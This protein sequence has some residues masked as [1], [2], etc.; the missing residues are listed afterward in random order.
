[1]KKLLQNLTIEECK[2]KLR[3][4]DIEN[5]LKKKSL[6]NITEY[7]YCTYIIKKNKALAT[8]QRDN[9]FKLDIFSN[10]SLKIKILNF[11]IKESQTLNLQEKD[12]IY[13]QSKKNLAILSSEINEI[14]N[15]ILTE[16]NIYGKS[17]IRDLLFYVDTLFYK[18]KSEATNYSEIASFLIDI[19]SKNIQNIHPNKDSFSDNITIS[20][21][22]INNLFS[23]ALKILK[24]L[25]ANKKIDSLEYYCSRNKKEFFIDSINEDFEKSIKQGYIHSNEQSLF[26]AINFNSYLKES[27]TIDEF[28]DK[29]IKDYSIFFT[30]KSHPIERYIFNTKNIIEFSQKLSKY[31]FKDEILI[32]ENLKKEYFIGI[33]DDEIFRFEISNK[34][35]IEDIFII[36]KIFKILNKINSEYLNSLLERDETK[37]QIIYNS[38]IKVFDKDNL[39]MLLNQ[40]INKDKAE[41]FVKTFSWDYKENEFFD[42]L[43]SPLIKFNESY[44]VATNIFS[45]SNLVRNVLFLKKI[46]P[47]D[48]FPQ[49]FISHEIYSALKKTF[50]FIKKEVKFDFK[51][52]NG[53]RIHG[54]FDVIALIEDTLFIF[55]IKNTLLGTSFHE[56]RSSMDKMNEGIQQIEKCKEALK[57]KDFITYLNNKLGW[58]IPNN[59]NIISSIVL[60][61]RIFNGYIKNNIRIFSSYE[62]IN[63]IQTGKV[64]PI[65]FPNQKIKKDISL[66]ENEEISKNDLTNYIEN[67]FFHKERFNNLEAYTEY[68]II[69]K[70]KLTF[71]TYQK[72]K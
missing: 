43:Y 32:F 35:T 58:K 68:I 15:N 7:A 64:T 52:K 59:V 16:L 36:H 70:S 21:N 17:L 62:L 60:G 27:L 2:S 29:N 5:S 3:N 24:F 22:K 66:W 1:M 4:I 54:D 48:S 11:L 14:Y 25:D 71:R 10:N 63:F 51:D 46:R 38:W 13:F 18:K 6:K 45:Y 67:G 42:L 44:Y 8:L 26:L 40:F 12:I 69:N 28:I 20:L 55:E 57:N 9:V 47:I 37:Q 30:L 19:Y 33:E 61:N 53:K 23:N 50:Q 41:D 49:D 65:S 34:N 31:F 72:K 56:I 39:I